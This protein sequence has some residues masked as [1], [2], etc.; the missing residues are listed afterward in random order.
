MILIMNMQHGLGDKRRNNHKWIG[1]KLS[2]AMCT[3]SK[4]RRKNCMRQ[5]RQ[6]IYRYK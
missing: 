2:K 1:M 5:R 6:K 4:M 3:M